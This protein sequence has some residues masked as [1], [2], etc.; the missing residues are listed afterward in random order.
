MVVPVKAAKCEF[1]PLLELQL[2]MHAVL[3][4]CGES[5]LTYKL[6]SMPVA[7]YLDYMASPTPSKR[8]VS[9]GGI[10]LLPTGPVNNLDAGVSSIFAASSQANRKP[11][12]NS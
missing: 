11:G 6:K 9:H 7:G 2:L 8:P 12:H 5:S 4:L 3:W 10:C 1:H